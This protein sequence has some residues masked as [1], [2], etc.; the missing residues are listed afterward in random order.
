MQTCLNDVMIQMTSPSFS[1]K[2]YH[3]A[4]LLLGSRFIISLILGFKFQEKEVNKDD[5]SYLKE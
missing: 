2:H 3:L 5:I 1:R 4:G